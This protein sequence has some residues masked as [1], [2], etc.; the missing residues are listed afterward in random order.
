M[1]EPLSVYKTKVHPDWIDFN[2]HMTEGF[3][4]VPFGVAAGKFLFNI[5][6]RKYVEET[7]CTIYAIQNII[8]YTKELKVNDQ[9][10]ITTQITN[11]N[12]YHLNF[13]HHMYHGDEGFLAAT[14]DTLFMHYSR[15][16]SSFSAMDNT[17]YK[18]FKSLLLPISKRNGSN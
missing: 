13:F 7:N 15:N 11:V 12:K 8:K 10:R 1:D 9:I 4:G 16:F 14:E 5:G 18:K 6:F 3:Y 2:N 17:I